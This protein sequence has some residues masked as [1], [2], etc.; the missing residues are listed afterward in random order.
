MKIAAICSFVMQAVQPAQSNWRGL[1]SRRCQQSERRHMQL[2]LHQTKAFFP[3][4][5]RKTAVPT[6][7]APAVRLYVQ[8]RIARLD[9]FKA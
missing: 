9:Y 6:I 4:P 3:S 2:A 7:L 5:C 1:G 8:T